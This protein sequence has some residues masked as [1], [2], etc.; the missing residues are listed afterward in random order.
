M[1]VILPSVYKDG[2]AT[3]AANGTAVTGQ[4]TLWLNSVLP[5]DF[6]GVHKGFP[7]RIATVNSNTSITLAN[8][9]PGAAQTAA[10]YEI[11][12]QSDNARMQETSRQLLAALSSGN[13]YA[14]SNLASAADTLGYFTG[15]GTMALTGLSPFMRT[16]LDDL[17]A[18]AVYGTLG[19]VPDGQL[20]Q[21]LKDVSTAVS[22]LNQALL[23]SGFYTTDGNTLNRPDGQNAFIINVLISANFQ[24]QLAILTENTGAV[25]TPR[26]Y[27]RKKAGG[28]WG[29]WRLTGLPILGTVSQSS[30]VPTGAIIER[31]SNANGEYVRFADG[32]Q[33]CWGQVDVTTLDMS[34]AMGS[35]FGSMTSFGTYPIAFLSQPTVQV[36]GYR[37]NNQPVIAWSK[38]PSSTTFSFSIWGPVALNNT[39]FKLVYW[40]AIGRWF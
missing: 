3:V 4:N 34:T 16:V 23:P 15:S 7:I 31:G 38:G 19:V 5:G 26:Q 17:N 14:L 35:G 10:A 25:N 29:S 18:S 13:A 20:K 36:Q 9:W 21:G 12:L 24:T 28:T 39:I 37:N 2:T 32:T 8:P 22:D 6:W 1:A 27:I 40:N 11:M 30:G 33:I